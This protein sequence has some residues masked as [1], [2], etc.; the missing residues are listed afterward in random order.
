MR[1]WKGSRETRLLTICHFCHGCLLLSFLTCRDAN[2]GWG[3]RSSTSEE[4]GLFIHCHRAARY[5]LHWNLACDLHSAA[6]L[7]QISC[8]HPKPVTVCWEHHIYALWTPSLTISSLQDKVMLKSWFPSSA[9]QQFSFPLLSFLPSLSLSSFLS[10][11]WHFHSHSTFSSVCSSP[12]A[13]FTDVPYVPCQRSS[14]AICL[15]WQLWDSHWECLR[16]YRAVLALH[17]GA[18][19]AQRRDA[20]ADT[21]HMHCALVA[22]LARLRLG[23]VSGPQGDGS[24]L[25]GRNENFPRMKKLRAVLWKHHKHTELHYL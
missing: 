14:Q 10:H 17:A 2:P 15:I 20:V 11:A 12:Q 1:G 5:A 7:P 25:A 23:K 21:L 3:G 24:D 9:I 6:K 16:S 4:N 22:S 18:V 19:E 13:V 8:I